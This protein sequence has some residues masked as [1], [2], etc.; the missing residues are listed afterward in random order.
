M[1]SQAESVLLKFLDNPGYVV[2][3][4]VGL[5]TLVLAIAYRQQVTFYLRF[6]SKSLFRNVV[7]TV[8]TALA[9]CVFVLVVI[10]IWSVFAFI[11]RVT[12]DKAKDFK[13]IAT[14]RWQIPSQ[15]PFAYA[16]TLVTGAASEPGDY[17]VNPDKDSMT[18][19]FYGGTLD[20]AKPTRENQVF[21][22]GMEPSKFLVMMEDVDQ[23]TAQEKT[24]IANAAIEMEADP[25]KVIIG[26]P[27]L[28]QINKK[29]GDRVKVT[30]FNYRDINLEIEIIG[31]LP[32]GRYGKVGVLNRAYLNRALEDYERQRGV[33]HP[34]V[35]KTLNLVWLRVPDRA[36][37]QRVAD[38]IENRGAY[39]NPSV[40]CEIG[41]SAIATF[42]EGY[43]GFF[44]VVRYL[45]A[46]AILI[47]MALVIAASIS[48]S[49]RERRAEMAVL[50]VLGFRPSQVMLLVL[51][52]ALL[53]G[54]VC[55]I[56]VGG[57]TWLIVNQVY[58]G[59]PLQIGFFPAFRVPI[60]AWWWG[61]GI[62]IFTAL[63]GSLIP[64]WSART[65]KVA[66]VFAK[67][68]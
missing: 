55:G 15:M 29:V 19:Q 51:G 30:S 21:F 1:P 34:M 43:R 12:A 6:I 66:E 42:L 65:V 38:Q 46:P 26:I 40:K 67:V 45:A 27:L 41:S 5:F 61:A 9:T 53:V 39:T 32:A 33:K 64:A 49:V 3:A 20:A 59:I 36:A 2:A 18:W 37:F 23:F 28:Q 44:W 17:R 62:G 24:D 57:G 7:R 52:E 13:I 48:I 10:L 31:T 22:F 60:D 56:L 58:G 35:N 25:R 68:A 50:K 11:D 16:T 4:G 54:A 63:A 8:L 14:E 47:T